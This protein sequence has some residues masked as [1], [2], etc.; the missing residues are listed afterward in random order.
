MTNLV[1]NAAKFAGAAGPIELVV[2]GAR[3]EV[4]DRGPGIAPDDLPKVFDRFHRSDAA[5]AL[6]GSGLG[7]SIVRDV[8]ERHG[9]TVFAAARDG[10]G[11][12]VGFEL[13]AHPVDAA[14]IP[15][16]AGGT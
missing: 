2:R 4:R 15:A 16:S 8:A 13:P 12:V 6:P 1:D 9:G 10:G 7:L 14:G 5:R 11:A 3:V